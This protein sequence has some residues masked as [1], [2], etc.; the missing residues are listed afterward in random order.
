MTTAPCP[1]YWIIETPDGP[2]SPGRCR[3]CGEEKEFNN[4]IEWTYR[5]QYRGKKEK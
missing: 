1:H 4:S 3:L 2:I 5:V